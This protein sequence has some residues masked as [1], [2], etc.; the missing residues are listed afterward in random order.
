MGLSDT[1]GWVSSSDAPNY[2]PDQNFTPE[3]VQQILKAIEANA[4]RRGNGYEVHSTSRGW[5]LGIPQKT[6]GKKL[7]F[8]VVT[9]Y[10]KNGLNYA[11]C[12]VGMVNRTIPKLDGTYLDKSGEPPAIAIGNHGYIGVLVTY[13]AGKVFPNEATIE[14]RTTLATNDNAI[15]SFFPLASI[16]IVDDVANIIQLSDT[17]LVVNRMKVGTEV[18]YWSWSN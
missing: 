11:N 15:T 4:P 8:F 9:V 1:T 7:R 6:A 14:Y 18:Y 13:Q 17:N 12:S 3:Y 16:D 5:T 10:R 2:R